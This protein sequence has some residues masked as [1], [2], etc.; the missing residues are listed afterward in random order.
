MWSGL[1]L[2]VLCA[3]L[4]FGAW[5]NLGLVLARRLAFPYALEWMEGGMLQHV[6]RLRQG[7]EL[8]GAPNPDFTPFPYPPLFPLMASWLPGESWSFLG[9][10]L[11]ALVGHAGVCVCLWAIARQRGLASNARA[12]GASVYAAGYAFSGG[13]YDV[14]RADGWALFLSLAGVVFL[15]GKGGRGRAV[16]AG[17]LFLLAGLAKQIGWPLGI[18]LSVAY[19]VERKPGARELWATWFVGAVGLYFWVPAVLGERA[20]FYIFEVLS[21]H[22]VALD[23]PALGA[24]FVVLLPGWL[25]GLWLVVRACKARESAPMWVALFVG[26][27]LVTLMG[28]VHLGAYD[29]VY[30]P[31]LVAAAFAAMM[32]LGLAE[33]WYGRNGVATRVVLGLVVMQLAALTYDR[34]PWIPTDGYRARMEC[35]EEEIAASSEPMFAPGHGYLLERHG[36][37]SGFH[38]MALFDLSAT[39]DGQVGVQLVERVRDRL[40]AGDYPRALCDRSADGLDLSGWL[41][42]FYGKRRVLELPEGEGGMPLPPSGAPWFASEI[43]T[44][45]VGGG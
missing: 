20:Y 39:G 5:F 17:V 36:L 33:R 9:P 45:P 31:A 13:W 43:L 29:N 22:E 37:A 1:M 32:G 14:A 24:K 6:E 18:L 25:L 23:G 38:W 16:A 21:G 12:L 35:V 19:S 10:R 15:W 4:M 8:Y 34:R 27:G 11:L 40:E 41:E 26:W 7:L 28:V 42:G 44:E 3:I 30:L 2:R